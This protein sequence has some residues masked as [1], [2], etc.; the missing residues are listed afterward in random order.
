[1]NFE[2]QKW[3][4]PG[5]E[6][7]EMVDQWKVSVETEVRRCEGIL[8]NPIHCGTP[9]S[10]VEYRKNCAIKKHSIRR[11]KNDFWRFFCK[12]SLVLFFGLMKHLHH[13]GVAID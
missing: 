12:Y 1:M 13:A 11:V 10:F 4:K 9:E 3:N 6:A 2:C 7:S 8:A 5:K